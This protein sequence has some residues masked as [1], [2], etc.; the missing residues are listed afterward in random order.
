[1]ASTSPL[2]G[3][4]DPISDSDVHHHGRPLQSNSPWAKQN[5]LTFGM[6]SDENLD[7]TQITRLISQMVAVFEGTTVYCTFSIS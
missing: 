1:M 7:L 2:T 3:C 5:V 4:F 6:S